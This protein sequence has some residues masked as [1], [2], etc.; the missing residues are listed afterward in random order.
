MY[1]YDTWLKNA[2]ENSV[3]ITDEGI[4]INVHVIIEKEDDLFSAH[5]L[6]FDLVGEGKTIKKAQ[7]SIINNIINYITFAI[8]KG[9]FDKIF[10]PAPP[11]YW[12]KLIRSQ[13]NGAWE[14]PRDKKPTPCDS[15]FPFKELTGKI[16][17]YQACYA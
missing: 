12:D 16:D 9:L 13:F 14:I 17:T 8:S 11:E 4:I 5:C 10:H 7:K 2:Y 1:V 3:R 6:E 15:P